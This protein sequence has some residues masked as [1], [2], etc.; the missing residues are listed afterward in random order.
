M[1][2]LAPERPQRRRGVFVMPKTFGELLRE[3][4]NARGWS[5]EYLADEA[6]VTQGLISKYETLGRKPKPETIH[7]LAKALDVDPAPLLFAAGYASGEEDV[8]PPRIAPGVRV[9]IDLGDGPK[10]G[11]LS[12]KT[13]RA[14]AE[15]LEDVKPVE[16]DR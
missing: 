2:V 15:L 8:T 10:E 3:L 14:I 7:K 4:R 1:G 11:T 9:I 16:S 5:G 12:E 13:L 6:G